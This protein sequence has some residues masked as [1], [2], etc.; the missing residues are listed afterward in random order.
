ML[1]LSPNH[2]IT[3]QSIELLIHYYSKRKKEGG[4]EKREKKNN[5]K[6]NY[7]TKLKIDNMKTTTQEKE[8]KIKI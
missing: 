2:I 6:F 1:Y 4:R 5:N 8:N 3:H 7:E